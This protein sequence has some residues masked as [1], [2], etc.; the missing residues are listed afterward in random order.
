MAE[1]AVELRVGCTAAVARMRHGEVDD[2]SEGTNSMVEIMS[3]F[4]ISTLTAPAGSY[5]ELCL[6]NMTNSAE[7]SGETFHCP[8]MSNLRSGVSSAHTNMI[9]KLIKIFFCIHRLLIA[10]GRRSKEGGEN[11]WWW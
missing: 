8:V 5:F 1:L 4:N 3:N 2:K 6:D 9:A 10:Q 7:E 11:Q